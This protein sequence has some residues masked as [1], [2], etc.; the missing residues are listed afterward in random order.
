MLLAVAVVLFE[1]EVR[2]Y[3]WRPRAI[4]SPYLATEWI[5]H[6]LWLHLPFAI[7][8]AVLWVYVFA[9]ALRNIPHPP[10]PGAWSGRHRF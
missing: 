3:P 9:W 1:I 7:S 6:A 4:G 5:D 2:V 8:A 10:R